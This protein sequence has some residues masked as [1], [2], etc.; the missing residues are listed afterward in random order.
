MK[1]SRFRYGL[2]MAVGI[3][4]LVL[5]RPYEGMLLCLPVAVVLGAMGVLGQRTGQAQ[6]S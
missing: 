3:V 6:Q 2:L 1:T 4:L 5:T